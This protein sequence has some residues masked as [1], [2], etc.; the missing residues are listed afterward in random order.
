MKYKHLLLMLLVLSFVY[1]QSDVNSINDFLEGINLTFTNK[2]INNIQETDNKL[3]LNLT[4]TTFVIEQNTDEIYVDVFPENCSKLGFVYMPGHGYDYVKE[5]I[6][7]TDYEGWALGMAYSRNDN[8]KFA[9]EDMTIFV[10]EATK[11]KLTPVIRIL[12]NNWQQEVMPV[13]SVIDFINNDDDFQSGWKPGDP[14]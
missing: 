8:Y 14:I 13:N 1:A 7:F 10:E 5:T 11:Q 12:G 2:T 9:L 6:Q 4:K 3:V